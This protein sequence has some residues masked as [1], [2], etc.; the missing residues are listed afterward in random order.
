MIFK[1]KKHFLW[2]GGGE[3][4]GGA[5]ASVGHQ[6]WGVTDEHIIFGKFV[7]I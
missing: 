6:K 4:G 3:G 2:G 1:T 7:K 5:Q